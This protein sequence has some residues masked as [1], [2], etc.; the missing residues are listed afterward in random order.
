VQ[1]SSRLSLSELTQ[2]E[3]LGQDSSLDWSKLVDADL[4]LAQLSVK[5]FT[6]PAQPPVSWN[7]VP[8]RLQTQLREM[9]SDVDVLSSVWDLDE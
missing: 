5:W 8:S 9:Q 1:H 3:V 4:R 6:A 7:S 2:I